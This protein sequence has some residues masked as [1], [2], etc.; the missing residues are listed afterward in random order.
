MKFLLANF[1]FVY[2][3]ETAVIGRIVKLYSYVTED[4]IRHHYKMQT[5]RAVVR[6]DR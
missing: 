1:V 2:E 4:T 5:A 6:T 3:R